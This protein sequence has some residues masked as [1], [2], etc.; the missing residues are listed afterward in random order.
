MNVPAR[1]GSVSVVI[2]AYNAAPRIRATLESVLSQTSEPLEIIVVDDGSTDDTAIVAQS[3]GS[4][5]KCI[6]EPH[7]GRPDRD[8]GI[9]EARGEFIAFVDADDTWHARK[10][11]LQL[12]RIEE[13]HRAWSICDAGWT[14]AN[15][16]I[17]DA[18]V[19]MPVEDGDILERLFLGNF[20][21]ASTPVVA[22][23]VFNVAGY[24]DDSPG[25][26]AGEDWDLWLRI[27]A[28]Y[29]VAG[30]QG[31]LATVCLH[32]DSLL[33]STP[34]DVKLRNLE[35]IVDRAAERESRLLHL[36]PR[37]LANLYYAAGVQL[38]RRRQTREALPYFAHALRLRPLHAETFGYMLLALLGGRVAN[39]AINLKRQL[40]KD[41]V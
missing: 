3:Y 5:V 20:I 28:R 36:R 14:G 7:R 25:L 2:A 19:F 38:I 4:I 23:Q 9:R 11:E 8:R 40:W 1:R 27:A 24:F 30:V 41:V 21:V 35:V 13:T 12:A 10:L 34:M 37:A 31:K 22:K 6:L 39:A 15:H 18:S 29:P 32:D 26:L 33:A 17:L 16:Q